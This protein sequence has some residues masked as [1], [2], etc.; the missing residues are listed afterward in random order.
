M[1]F[2]TETAGLP[3]LI[4]F[5]VIVIEFFGALSLILGFATRI[6]SLA[7]IG[8]SLGI[9]FHSHIKNGFFMNWEQSQ[10]G[11]GIEYFLLLISLAAITT[12]AGAG[13][14]SVDRLLARN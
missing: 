11:E 10:A 9:M 4:G 6:W 5:L 14:A 3:W 1:Q 12:Y 2:F 8:L 7:I 13:R